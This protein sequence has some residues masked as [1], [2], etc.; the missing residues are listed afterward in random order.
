MVDQHREDQDGHQFPSHPCVESHAESKQEDFPQCWRSPWLTQV[1]PAMDMTMKTQAKAIQNGHA[2]KVTSV[3]A[4][5]VA[6]VSPCEPQCLFET[7]AASR[8][9]AWKSE[10]G[11]TRP[12]PW[13][14][15]PPCCLALPWP[16]VSPKTTRLPPGS[17]WRVPQSPKADRG[18]PE[19]EAPCQT[20]RRTPPRQ[21]EMLANVA[22]QT[23]HVLGVPSGL[24]GLGHAGNR[25]PAKLKQN[26]GRGCVAANQSHSA[27]ASRFNVVPDAPA[28]A[29]CAP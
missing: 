9:L 3:M 26:H 7:F 29:G 25:I 10:C 4:C 23:S 8:A 15:N 16:I 5:G 27:R 22:N 11:R 2:V 1:C 19:D 21:R 6:H 28:W 14:A 24:F 12:I 20:G 17:L 13:H 18:S